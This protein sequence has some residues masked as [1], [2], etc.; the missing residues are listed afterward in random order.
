[1]P[2]ILGSR[3]EVERIER[4]HREFLNGED[5]PFS[6]PLFCQTHT[7]PR[8]LSD[9]AS[10]FTQHFQIHR[11]R[12]PMSIK[13]PV[14]AITG[15]SGAGTTSVTRFFQHIFRREEINAAIIEGDSFHRYDRMAMKTKMEEFTAGR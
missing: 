5:Q 9:A 6:S 15:S 10:S 13:H 14:I 4:Y 2:V 7:L 8:R 3:D 11:R 12:S 1:V